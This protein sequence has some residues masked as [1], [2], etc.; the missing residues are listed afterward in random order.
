MP[1]DPDTVR[2]VTYVTAQ[3]ERQAVV[4]ARTL[5][6]ARQLGAKALRTDWTRVWAVVPYEGE[7]DEDAVSRVQVLREIGWGAA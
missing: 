2:W 3:P 1:A 7:S 6:V 5:L 4:E